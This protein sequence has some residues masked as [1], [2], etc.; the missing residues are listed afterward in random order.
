M[1][2]GVDGFSTVAAV[3][4]LKPMNPSCGYQVPFPSRRFMYYEVTIESFN[5]PEDNAS[6]QLGWT[7]AS[8]ERNSDQPSDGNGVG[9][10]DHSWGMDG[11]RSISYEI[12]QKMRAMY[13]KQLADAQETL[14]RQFPSAEGLKPALDDLRGPNLQVYIDKISVL[15][16]EKC[17]LMRQG[18]VAESDISQ[19]RKE[20]EKTKH[21]LRSRF[22][23]RTNIIEQMAM[24][25]KKWD[26]KRGD[27][28]KQ[29]KLNSMSVDR[30]LMCFHNIGSDLGD[31]SCACTDGMQDALKTKVSLKW[32]AKSVIGVWFDSDACE[33]GIVRS[34]GVKQTAFRRSDTA[35][36]EDLNSVHWKED[37]IVPCI[38]GRGVNI[39]INLGILGGEKFEFFDSEQLVFTEK[40]SSSVKSQVFEIS[41]FKDG[42]IITPRPHILKNGQ[43][44]RFEFAK[45]GIVPELVLSS[46]HVNR[47]YM[48]KCHG[49]HH[50]Q[51]VVFTAQGASSNAIEKDQPYIVD[52]RDDDSFSLL[53]VELKE[54]LPYRVKL[55][56][57]DAS[58]SF[59]ILRTGIP[60]GTYISD[61]LQFPRV[62][63]NGK[64]DRALWGPYGDTPADVT[65]LYNRFYEEDGLRSIG[66]LEAIY[67]RD[68]KMVK[69]DITNNMKH[70]FKPELVSIQATEHCAQTG[71][72]TCENHGL[73]KGQ[74][75]QF[76]KQDQPNGIVLGQ[77]YTVDLENGSENSQ[78]RLVI[79][80]QDEICFLKVYN[81]LNLPNMTIGDG[82]WP[83]QDASGRAVNPFAVK[84][85]ATKE[86][87]LK[88]AL[89]TAFAPPSRETAQE[90]PNFAFSNGLPVVPQYDKLSDIIFSSFLP[91]CLRSSCVELLRSCFVDQEP[92]FL[93]PPINTVRAVSAEPSN[94]ATKCSGGYPAEELNSYDYKVG[95]ELPDLAG[96]CGYQ[97]ADVKFFDD[98]FDAAG[99]EQS[100]EKN[101]KNF[102]DKDWDSSQYKPRKIFLL[103]EYRY[104][105]GRFELCTRD[106]AVFWGRSSCLLWEKSL[107]SRFLSEKNQD[108]K[109]FLK[110]LIYCLLDT[111]RY[112]FDESWLGIINV[113]KRIV[114]DME[115]CILTYFKQTQIA[116]IIADTLKQTQ[117]LTSSDSSTATA[118]DT[119]FTLSKLLSHFRRS[120][121]HV[122]LRE[123]DIVVAEEFVEHR[124]KSPVP[125]AVIS[126]LRYVSDHASPYS[127]HSKSQGSNS[128]YSYFDWQNLNIKIS[129]YKP[130]SFSSEQVRFIVSILS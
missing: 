48:H 21:I 70:F 31:T 61:P 19:I 83:K 121:L 103:H 88:F 44:V 13:E 37:D 128:P 75:V 34:D 97:E 114:K 52:V 82:F 100:E 59:R 2:F 50:N 38:S 24:A 42:K 113:R 53:K 124:Y 51:V 43:Y 109:I 79:F 6:L 73:K 62:H 122:G 12:A 107:K 17:D 129:E 108:I 49:L 105:K 110:N 72:Y 3:T 35:F 126:D 93:T 69:E 99:W 95:K 65:E 46:D 125:E 40:P 118:A 14:R 117:N 11:V 116:Q 20:V 67:E 120:E 89:C 87:S 94:P 57:E 55:C 36:F 92:W 86:R 104:P 111:L 115:L 119:P 84:A 29:S 101:P 10:F 85:P 63:L 96:C 80:H 39:K 1:A 112:Q 15:L 98:V 8:K 66:N 25:K 5:G 28:Q 32:T 74:F 4:N 9:D 64:V 16:N 41:E 78:F 68:G 22:S 130:S 127:A 23:H 27:E 102:G 45:T 123:D 56:K 7:L 60:D 58:N 77:A 81:A 90:I 54:R 30:G 18:T 106:V 76:C 26:S 91:V 47:H 33:I 71:I